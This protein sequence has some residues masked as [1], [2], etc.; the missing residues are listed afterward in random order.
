MFLLWQIFPTVAVAAGVAAIMTAFSL[1]AKGARSSQALAAFAL[2]AGYF[3]GHVSITGW[4]PFPPMDTTNWLPY[5]AIS[6]AAIGSLSVLLSP[7]LARIAV[8]GLFCAGTMRLLLAPKFRYGWSAEEGWLWVGGLGCA[9]LLL[10]LS[11]E[12]SAGR[13][14]IA[15]EPALILTIVSAGTACCL[16]LSGSLLLGQ[17]AAALSAATFGSLLLTRRGQ[18]V[19]ASATSVFSLLLVALL[20][21]GYFFAE[22]PALSA[23]LLVAAPVGSLIPIGIA[24]LRWVIAA[25]V[26]VAIT[27]VSGAILAAY[28]LSPS[29]SE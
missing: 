27:T 2:G 21:S 3:A 9:A 15:T 25:R 16:M 14:S 5:F 4:T 17:F 1:R 22:L 6:G 23:L 18:T 29:W 11:L 20:V 24:A 28:R 13:S 19:G 12:V 8:L 26:I 10:A 7:K